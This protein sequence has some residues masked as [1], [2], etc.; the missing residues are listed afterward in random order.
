MPYIAC[1]RYHEPLVDTLLGVVLALSNRRTLIV[2]ANEL[3]SV[4]PE[5]LTCQP[6]VK[7]AL[8]SWPGKNT[9]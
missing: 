5:P 9:Y 2:I 3:R 4:R 1:P 7:D 6:R 8:H